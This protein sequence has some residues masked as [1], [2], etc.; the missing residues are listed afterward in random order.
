MKPPWWEKIHDADI[1]D[2]WRIEGTKDV[3]TAEQVTDHFAKFVP[4]DTDTVA[5]NDNAEDESVRASDLYK[6]TQK[7][8]DF[9]KQELE[10]MA[11]E[12][13]LYITAPSDYPFF[14]AEDPAIVAPVTAP[15]LVI[16]DYSVPESLRIALV[17]AAAPFEEQA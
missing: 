1:V 10:Y 12:E 4:V 17:Q 13:T 9:M 7:E 15:G 8:F 3:E 5:D 14:L 2:K 16:S 11:N 6:L